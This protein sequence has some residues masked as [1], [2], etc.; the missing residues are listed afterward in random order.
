MGDAEVEG[1][2]FVYYFPV[3]FKKGL[4]KIRH[5]YRFRGGE[6]VE[7]QR[8]FS[9]QITTGKRW[10]N[11]QI[12]EFELQ[13]HLDNGIFAIPAS[14]QKDE[15]FANWQITGDGVIENQARQWFSEENPKVRM[16]HLNNGYLLF[17]AKNFKPDNDLF[18]GE[19]NWAAGWINIWCDFGQKC[20]ER[21]SLEKVARFFDLNPWQDYT[22]EDFAELGAKEIKY[23][24]NYFYAVRG[25]PFK[26]AELKRFYSQFFWYKPNKS[27]K[28]ENIKLSEAESK[29]LKKL[30]DYEEK[31]KK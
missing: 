1:R 17:K 15:K 28:I 18:F 24:C 10:A 6:S 2:D 29:F 4:N 21:E 13:I 20:I 9:Y 16:A 27:V 5:T 23:V 14:F 26:D 25:F 19:Y 3:T 12:D 30:K 8:D 7:L 22:D 11:K 31:R